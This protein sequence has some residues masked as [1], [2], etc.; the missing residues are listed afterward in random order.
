[1]LYRS[2][3]N[4]SGEQVAKLSAKGIAGDTDSRGLR[5]TAQVKK[6]IVTL[7]QNTKKYTFLVSRKL[8][9]ENTPRNRAVV[10]SAAKYYETILKLAES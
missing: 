6:N 8:A 5:M 3:Y 9:K 1:V 2:L 10:A 7:R 4:T